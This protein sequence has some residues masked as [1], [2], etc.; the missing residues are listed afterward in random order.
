[1]KSIATP[2]CGV[3]QPEATVQTNVNDNWYLRGITDDRAVP[4]CNANGV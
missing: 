3:S 1:M 4:D 2:S